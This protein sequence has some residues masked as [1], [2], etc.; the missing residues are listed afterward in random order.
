[1]AKHLGIESFLIP[2]MPDVGTGRGNANAL[3][4]A[5]ESAGNPLL[6][7][8]LKAARRPSLRSPR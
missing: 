3:I 1:M 2:V 6:A 5:I 7:L 4:V 8:S